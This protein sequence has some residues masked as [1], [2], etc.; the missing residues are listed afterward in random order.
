MIGFES[1]LLET[2]KYLGT[3]VKLPPRKNLPKQMMITFDLLGPCVQLLLQTQMLN[4]LMSKPFPQPG[5]R[6]CELPSPTITSKVIP[7]GG[8]SLL[9]VS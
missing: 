7:Q 1:N 3:E 4:L 6:V 9:S 8:G 5:L 2:I